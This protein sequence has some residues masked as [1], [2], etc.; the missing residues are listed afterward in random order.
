MK[1]SCYMKRSQSRGSGIRKPMPPRN[2][3]T[4]TPGHQPQP[5][6]RRSDMAHAGAKNTARPLGPQN[7]SMIAP[8]MLPDGYTDI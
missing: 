8:A 6:F 7:A 4:S 2:L 5:H 1:T 3:D